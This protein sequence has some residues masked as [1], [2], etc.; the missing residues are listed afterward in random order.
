MSNSRIVLLIIVVGTAIRLLLAGLTGLGYDESYMVG[1]ARLFSLSYVDHAPLHV[2]ITWAMEHI[3]ASE[4]P[5]VVR[6]PFVLLFAGSTWLMYRLTARLFG[7]R[8]GLWAVIAFSL[9]PVFSFSHASWVLPDGPAIFFLLAAANVVERILFDARPMRSPTVWWLGAGVLAGLAILSKYNAAF[10]MVAVLLYLLTVPSA[11]RYLATIG[12]WLGAVA[13]LIVSIPI[14][15]WNLEHGLIGLFFQTRR[16]GAP[17]IH[18][19]FL[20]ED[21][22]GQALYLTPWLFVPFLISLTNA[23]RKGRHDPGGW[24]MALAAAGPI[25]LFTFFSLWAHGLPHWAMPGWLF[26]IPLF[27]RDAAELATRRPKFAH[28]YMAAAAAVFFAL[29][30][31]FMVQ[32]TRG[33]L[34]PTAIV[35]QNPALD[36]TVDLINWTELKTALA[37]RGLIGHGEVVASPIWM[38]AGKTSYALGPDVPVVC[39]C[40]DAQHFAFRYDQHQWAGRD[41]VVIAPKG[42]DWLWDVAGRYFDS[43]EPLPP[44][45]IT[46]NGEAVMTLDLRLGENLHFPAK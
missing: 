37:E 21:I 10:F 42:I 16:V 18:L 36:P 1:N 14:I 40:D 44:V 5:I 6:L 8:A 30:I 24:L 29:L 46:R 45:A 19:N 34:M 31:V 32:V 38:F 41:M 33:G 26:A 20:A 35:A 12:P 13:A 15:V 23:L 28:G 7:Q 39:V 11:R 9:A 22:G 2:W 3:F 43:F 17:S 25:G 27:G 4:A